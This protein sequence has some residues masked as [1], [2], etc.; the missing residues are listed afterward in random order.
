VTPVSA[1]PAPRLGDLA[2]VDASLRLV[3][4]PSTRIEGISYDLRTVS[5]G[6]LFVALDGD[7]HSGRSSARD[8]VARGARAVLASDRVE[9]N[10][11]LLLAPDVRAAM[12]RVSAAFH[13][14][15]SQAINVI[16]VT[17]TDGKTTTAH[18]LEAILRC[19]GLHTGSITTVGVRIGNVAKPPSGRLTTPESSDLQAYLR[20]M[21]DAGDTWAVVEATSHGLSLKRLDEVRFAVGA[22]TNVTHEHL[23]FHGTSARYRRAKAIL[24]ERVSESRGVAVVNL[25]DEGAR[26][27]LPYIGRSSLISYGA[28]AP[29]ADVRAADVRTGRAGSRFTLL[30]PNGRIPVRLPLLGSF[31]VANA[32]CAAACALAAGVDAETTARGLEGAPPVPGR[33]MRI[34]LG[35]PFAVVV[36]YA[37]TPTALAPVLE[38]LRS[39]HP[40]GRLIAVL[41]S[42]GQRDLLKRPWLGEICA[43]LADYSVFTSEDPRLEDATSIIR[44]IAAGAV[45]VGGR[46]GETFVCLADRRDAISHALSRA[47][48]GD[49]VLLAGKGHERSMVWGSEERPWDEA[50]IA[51]QLLIDLD[52]GGDGDCS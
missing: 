50:R 52:Y 10:T 25:D 32:L 44:Q 18:L 17:G 3:G 11:A 14:H 28:H 49:C 30:T 31:N 40:H 37:H 29:Q 42:A 39:L 43:R 27:L 1:A 12:A 16:G 15:P 36:D 9:A 13:A 41:G 2:A 51:R 7:D 33:L 19:A 20:Q 47:R 24:F 35:Q 23:D 48:T 8:A 38:L 5:D 46:E 21:V 34:E 45:S 22:L 26:E 6:D 4:D